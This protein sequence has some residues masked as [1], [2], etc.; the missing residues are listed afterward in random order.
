MP[1]DEGPYAMRFPILGLSQ[2]PREFIRGV[3]QRTV[4]LEGELAAQRQANAELQVAV[5]HAEAQATMPR[6]EATNVR[7]AQQVASTAA[8]ST[9]VSALGDKGKFGKGKGK[10]SKGFNPDDVDAMRIHLW[11]KCDQCKMTKKGLDVAEPNKYGE[12]SYMSGVELVWTE[13]GQRLHMSRDCVSLQRSN[14]LRSK[15]ICKLCAR[16]HP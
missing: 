14:N 5:L 1:T 7:R 11:K 6:A 12:E 9:E 3:M 8:S 4:A 2:M 15:A 13:R 10:K 16:N